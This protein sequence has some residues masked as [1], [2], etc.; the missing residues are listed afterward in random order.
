MTP[1]STPKYTHTKNM[2]MLTNKQTK[3]KNVA[4]PHKNK[5][6]DAKLDL[7]LE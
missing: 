6:T 1:K 7:R 2:H 3:S 4:Y 5:D